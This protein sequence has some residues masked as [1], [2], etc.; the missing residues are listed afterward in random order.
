[1]QEILLGLQYMTLIR[2]NHGLCAP[3][4]GYHNVKMFQNFIVQNIWQVVEVHDIINSLYL[5]YSHIDWSSRMFCEPFATNFKISRTSLFFNRWFIHGFHWRMFEQFLLFL[6]AN[7]QLHTLFTDFTH[8]T[9]DTC[10]HSMTYFYTHPTYF[11][12]THRYMQT[13]IQTYTY[14]YTQWVMLTRVLQ[15]LLQ[16][17]KLHV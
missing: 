12:L 11:T 5:A 6:L 16:T 15:Y 13:H 17:T 8:F 2:G 9:L 10:R 1:M 3:Q 14:R 4:F 7:T